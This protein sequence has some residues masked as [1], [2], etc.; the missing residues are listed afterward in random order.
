M[1]YSQRRSELIKKQNEEL[2][3]TLDMHQHTITRMVERHRLQ[4]A[5][6]MISEMPNEKINDVLSL[7][8][9]PLLQL[10]KEEHPGTADYEDARWYLR[11]LDELHERLVELKS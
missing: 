8:R 10:M 9:S 11:R 4:L 6:L 3:R 5:E 7:L 2:Q 1:N